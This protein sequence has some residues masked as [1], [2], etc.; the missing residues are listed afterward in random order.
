MPP[1]ATDP[2]WLKYF[3]VFWWDSFKIQLL[4]NPGVQIML[5]QAVFLGFIV[6]YLRKILE[7]MK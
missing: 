7:R 4:T 5:L 3:Y 6:Y 2:T 1:L